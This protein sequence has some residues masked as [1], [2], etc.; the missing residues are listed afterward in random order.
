VD[1]QLASKVNRKEDEPSDRCRR[2]K[3]G[4]QLIRR[5]IQRA[6]KVILYEKVLEKRV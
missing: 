1:A 6:V 3:D 2:E 4:S 5:A